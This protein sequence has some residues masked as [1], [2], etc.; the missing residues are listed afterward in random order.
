MS[1]HFNPRL[2]MSFSWLFK[3]IDWV[4]LGA[5]VFLS[6]LGI[7]ELT[8]FKNSSGLPV[9]AQRQA[10]YLALGIAVV[11]FVAN[12][13]YGFFRT[14]KHGAVFLYAFSVLLLAAL[15]FTNQVTRGTVGW[16]KFGIF[17]FEPSEL[18][19]F[20][21]ITILAKYFSWRHVEISRPVHILISAAYLVLPAAL[22]ILQPD[23]GSV[24][25]LSAI[26]FV[27]VL[28]SGIKFRHLILVILTGI[29]IGVSG[30]IFVL[31]PYQ[32]A[33]IASFIFPQAYSQSASYNQTQSIITIGSSGFFGK[34]FAENF[35]TKYGFLPSASTDFIFA[36][37]TESFGFL[38]A[39]LIL[40]LY[41]VLLWRIVRAAFYTSN[42]FS[43]LFLIGL[44]AFL[45]AQIFVNVGMNLGIMPVT[46]ITLPLVSFGGSSMIITFLSLGIAE[47]I[48][49]RS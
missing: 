24:I 26:W 40:A 4:L 7:L 32:K 41:L 47:S 21:L 19:K 43:R 1:S 14:Y 15:F 18:M 48:I 13:D 39:F 11:F 23:L 2:P 12:L 35:Q 27:V 5:A 34:G 10:I 33:R 17:N 36:A 16:F 44:F 22:I 20:S 3:K 30:W 28:F 29:I 31:A 42:N 49:V 6:L 45:F 8:Q 38:G 9:Y 37:F 25:I 46:G